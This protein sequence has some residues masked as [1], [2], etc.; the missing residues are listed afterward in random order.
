MSRARPVTLPTGETL[1]FDTALNG[2]RATGDQL[3]LLVSVTGDELDDLLDANVTQ[4]ELVRRLREALDQG[5]IPEDVLERQRLY[6]AMR[7]LD[8]ECR[9]CGRPDNSTRHHFVNK[10]I[11]KELSNYRDVGARTRCTVPVCIECHRDLH[12]RNN[13]A[14]SIVGYLTAEER[15]FASELIE[16]LRRER[17]DIFNLLAEGD[18]SVYEAR[19]VKDWLDGHF[20]H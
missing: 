13:E 17:P 20:D 15:H 12:D 14:V 9:C 19:L 11:M 7:K 16:R 5:C 4:G 1:W 10:W 3:E 18:D 6:K 8:P 2:T